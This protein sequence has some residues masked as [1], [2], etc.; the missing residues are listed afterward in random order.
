MPNSITLVEIV[1]TAL[2]PRRNQAQDQ[3]SGSIACR[4]LNLEGALLSLLLAGSGG[5][6]DTPAWSP[7]RRHLA[8]RVVR[9]APSGIST[10]STRSGEIRVE[11]VS[12]AK[13]I[14]GKTNF[15]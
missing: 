10:T 12:S 14:Y 3:F 13:E 8:A 6:F 4:Y 1:D 5:D 7:D 11:S 2:S 9:A 15:Y